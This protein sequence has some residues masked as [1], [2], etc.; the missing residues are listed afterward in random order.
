MNTDNQLNQVTLVVLAKRP[1]PGRTKTRLTPPLHPN[2]AARI[3]A[4]CLSDT[5]RVVSSSPA[6]RRVL[7]FAGDPDGWLP[8]GWQLHRQC[9]GGLDER[10]ADALGAVDGPALLVGMDTPQ[11][12]AAH[13]G[14]FDPGRFDAALGYAPD[15]GYWG[16][17]LRDTGRA[18]QAVLGVGMS[19]ASTGALQRDR[20]IALGM[21][22]Q[23]LSTLT[24]I[25][26]IQTA[27]EVAA[28]ATG[29]ELARVLSAVDLDAPAR[30]A[31]ASDASAR[32]ACA[33]EGVGRG[34]FRRV[35]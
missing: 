23:V 28:L 9:S 30:D 25:D 14:A 3:A 16:I 10:L 32:G 24:D 2:D 18:A 20:L 35:G 13:L 12:L 8:P 4:A 6:R 15:G 5:L 17:G 22:V 1:E 7:A 26:T 27:R 21:R 19:L 33:G 31:S 11:L 29:T 34:A